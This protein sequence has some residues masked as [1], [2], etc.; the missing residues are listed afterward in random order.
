MPT[1]TKPR[2]RPPLACDAPIDRRPVVDLVLA[3]LDVGPSSVAALSRLL[4][5]EEIDRA[6]HFVRP[7]HASRF[8]V[9]RAALR[10]TLGRA[11][12]CP[13][14]EVPLH[15]SPCS[16][17]GGPHGKPRVAG[18]QLG[19]NLAHSAD[20]AAIALSTEHEVGVD[21]ERVRAGFP[22]EAI[23]DQ[24][25][26]AQEG[27]HVRAV[28][29]S[30]RSRAFLEIWTRKEA[31]VKATGEGLGRSF[32]TFSV[33]RS[34]GVLTLANGSTWTVAAVDAGPAYVGAIAL[35][36][37]HR[38][39]A[40]VRTTTLDLRAQALPGTLPSWR[41]FDAGPGVRS[42]MHGDGGQLSLAGWGAASAAP[43][44]GRASSC[45]VSVHVIDVSRGAPVWRARVA[46]R[47]T[48]GRGVHAQVTDERGRADGFGPFGPGA[49]DVSVDLPS[50]AGPERLVEGLTA[51]V[52]LE[53][54]HHHL[55]ILV[56][57]GSVQLYRGAR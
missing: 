45:T 31:V 27:A 20:L 14:R 49:H 39:G 9:A 15:R 47:G 2:A 28:A 32:D 24:F 22:Y 7:L 21:V 54:G 52:W 29:P 41:H 12:Q 48:G 51:R 30:R 25:L 55:P 5:H 16:G 50:G 34:H 57:D 42:D 1:T 11:L 40:M 46:V 35:G 53:P 6:R 19:F 43:R 56:S 36:G 13:P 38:A 18:R 23:A 8:V 26:H 10:I 17:C 37:C 44:S 33:L 3:P 4:V